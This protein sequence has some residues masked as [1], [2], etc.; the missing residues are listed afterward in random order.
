MSDEADQLDALRRE[1][2]IGLDQIN[3]GQVMDGRVASDRVRARLKQRDH[4]VAERIRPEQDEST[5]QP[6]AHLASLGQQEADLLDEGEWL[7]REIQL[8][9]ESAENEPLIPGDE[10]VE[11]M[12]ARARR[13]R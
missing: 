9:I 8:S 5:N 6:K 2:Q 11:R 1:I 3:R 13:S 4:A 10:V 12:R 7:R